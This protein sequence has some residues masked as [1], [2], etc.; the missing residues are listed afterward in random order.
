MS[1]LFQEVQHTLEA[2]LEH[3]RETHRQI[4]AC[5]Q[6]LKVGSMGEAPKRGR[7]PKQT[8]EKEPEF[9]KTA[10]GFTCSRCGKA[11]KR[12]LLLWRHERSAH[13]IFQRKEK[14]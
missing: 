9:E 3:D 7:P 6:M 8:Q 10:L 5:Y 13:G 11:Y 4:E 1:R 12:H 14:K 2:L